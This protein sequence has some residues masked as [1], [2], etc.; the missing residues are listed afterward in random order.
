LLGLHLTVENYRLRFVIEGIEVP[1]GDELLNRLNE[2]LSAK[3]KVILDNLQMLKDEC[4]KTEEVK[5]REEGAVR[6]K[7]EALNEIERLKALLKQK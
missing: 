4:K 1:Y 6:E 7:N 5:S 2:K 3:D